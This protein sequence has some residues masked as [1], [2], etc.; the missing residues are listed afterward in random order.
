MKVPT[1][2]CQK[3]STADDH[4]VL[5]RGDEN[6]QNWKKS[7]LERIKILLLTLKAYNVSAGFHKRNKEQ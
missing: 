2:M 1:R 5:G 6:T 4:K 7:H 3:V